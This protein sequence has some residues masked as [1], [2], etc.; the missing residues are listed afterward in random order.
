MLLSPAR[1]ILIKVS[2]LCLPDMCLFSLVLVLPRM[3]LP[4][5][6]RKVEG[7]LDPWR[8]ASSMVAEGQG[9]DATTRLPDRFWLIE[10]NKKSVWK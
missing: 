10:Q 6:L 9:K 1:E 4:Q 8:A 5:A 7:V 3:R 2:H